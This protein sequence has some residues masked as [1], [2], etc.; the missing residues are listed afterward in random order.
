MEVGVGRENVQ[1]RGEADEV[2][3]EVAG[4]GDQAFFVLR[5]EG[6]AQGVERPVLEGGVG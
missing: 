4:E 5:D 6:G 2:D 1:A 3:G